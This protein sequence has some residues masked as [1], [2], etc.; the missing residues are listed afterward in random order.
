MLLGLK[1]LSYWNL[2]LAN[3]L[4]SI[5]PKL[6]K[7]LSYW[8]LN[9]D[10]FILKPKK[11]ILKVLSYWNLNIN[12]VKIKIGDGSLKYYHIGI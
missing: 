4:G 6:L 2:N 5:C 9:I 7:V 1:V 10:C 12:F 8:N 3:S 11:S